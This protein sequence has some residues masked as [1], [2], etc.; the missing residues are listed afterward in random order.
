MNRHL[1]EIFNECIERL[2]QGDSIENCLLNYPEEAAEIEPLLRTASNIN[3]RASMVQPRPDFKA[4]A[5]YQFINAQYAEAQAKEAKAH[6]TLF[7]LQRAWM[8]A[9]VMILLLVFS[10]VGTA[11]AASNAMPDQP[12]YSVKLATEQVQLT[13]AFS[14]ETKANLNAKLVETRSQEIITM[15]TQGKTDQV[16]ATTARMA[17]N[18]EAAEAAIN[19][20]EDAKTR[21]FSPPPRPAT[22]APTQPVP[23]QPLPPPASSDKTKENT[24]Q[25]GGQTT[26]TRAS[27]EAGKL[28]QSVTASINKNITALE[29]AQDKTSDKAK[30]ALQKAIELTK[31]KHTQIQKTRDTDTKDKPGINLPPPQG[32]V[33]KAFSPGDKDDDNDKPSNVKPGT[34]INPPPPP[35]VKGGSG[36]TG[37]GGNLPINPA[38]NDKD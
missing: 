24:G 20:V 19:K 2:R 30:E 38:S 35:P 18:L 16:I 3:W 7:N 15:A 33:P 37:N 23:S 28:R 9:L 17:Q 14:D 26:T 27:V 6:P 34:K 5:R 29:N 21:Q 13:L 11:A 8:P 36:T 12:L 25:A 31:N 32:S 1:E 22:L 4:R 10:S